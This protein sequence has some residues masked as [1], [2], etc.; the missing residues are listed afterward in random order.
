MFLKRV[1]MSLIKCVERLPRIYSLISIMP[2]G[3]PEESAEKPEL[4]SCTLFKSR[5]AL[6]LNRIADL[7][8]LNSGFNADPGLL[9]G[10]MGIAIFLYHYARLT[11]KEMY[12]TC[13]GELID[14][15]CLTISTQTPVDFTNGLT[16]IGWGIEYLVR[17]G[18]VDADTD[19]VLTEIDNAIY[20]KWLQRSFL[21]D[22]N[23][24]LFGYGFYYLARLR[25]KKNYDKNRNNILK[26]QSLISFT[27]GCE[28]VL[29]S[30]RFTG[31]NS[32]SLSRG[33]INSIAWFLLET[34]K[35][36][37]FPVRVEKLLQHLP[38]AMDFT[39]QKTDDWAEDFILWHIV[40]NI[41]PLIPDARVQQKFIAL[42][43]LLTDKT[44][45]TNQD[46]ESFV[47][48]LA[49]IAWQKMIYFPYIKA[50]SQLHQITR[51][52]FKIIDDE[53]NWSQ[54]IDKLTVNNMG[55]TG[56]AGMGL[57]LME[58]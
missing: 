42:A 24:D 16:G 44:L 32:S 52:V 49:A 23:N 35:L 4:I 12:D 47:N 50:D 39:P 30:G 58:L 53:E 51:K 36:K 28:R 25:G 3:T 13:A 10:K 1:I 43:E 54:R 9:N 11:G 33:T 22:N 31:F 48:N 2:K 26:E 55:L 15:I 37:I 29:V 17:N 38:S 7:L 41:I 5:L 8:F 21:P 40:Q 45:E 57:G 14:E 27:D 46:D 34:H 19:E 6:R 18:F 56:L 20:N